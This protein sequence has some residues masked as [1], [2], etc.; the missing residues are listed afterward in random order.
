MSERKFRLSERASED[1][2]NI[3]TNVFEQS[4]SLSVAD[5]VIDAIYDGIEFLGENPEVGHYREDLHPKPMKFMSVF[6]YL[7]IY[8]VADLVEIARVL[9]SQMDV[10]QILKSENPQY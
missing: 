4:L 5:K 7:I 2:D 10:E 3:W 6:S 1:I 9:P 8:R